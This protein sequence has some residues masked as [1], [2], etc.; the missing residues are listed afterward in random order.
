MKYLCIIECQIE[1]IA[2]ILKKEVER[3]EHDEMECRAYF[4]QGGQSNSS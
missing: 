3:L 1:T 2:M 4:T